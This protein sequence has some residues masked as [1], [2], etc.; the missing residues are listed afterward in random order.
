MK[1]SPDKERWQTPPEIWEP[2]MDEF[3]FDLDAAA[4]DR[5]KRLWNYLDDA[6]GPNPWQGNV[7]WM[8]P[9]YGH[10]LEPFVRRAAKEAARGKV[11]V[12]LIPFRCR[13]A[14]WHE[15]VIDRAIEVRCVRGRISFLRLDGTRGAFTGSCDSCIVV[16]SGMGTGHTIVKS[17]TPAPMVRYSKTHAQPRIPP[18]QT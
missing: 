18:Q 17:F 10:K 14:W 16:W 1:T 11:V 12:A 3:S 9:P 2:L 13:G 15:C 8:N 4:D 6:L 5:T 7:I